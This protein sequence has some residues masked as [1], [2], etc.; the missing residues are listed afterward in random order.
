[1]RE[2]A[3]GKWVVDWVAKRTNEFGN[4]GTSAGIGALKDGLLVAGVAYAEWN[5]VNVVCHIAAEGKLWATRQFLW[6]IFDYPFN[7]L[8]C[9]RITVCIGEGNKP[10]RNLVERMGFTQEANLQGAHPTGDLIVYSMFK[11]GCKY[12]ETPYAK[13]RTDL[14]RA[15]A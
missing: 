12:L 15:A 2:I 3:T 11:S 7:Q 9:N 4:F 5:G 1:M 6:T 14:V 10:S 8:K 13:F